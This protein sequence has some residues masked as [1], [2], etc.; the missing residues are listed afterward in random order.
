MFAAFRPIHPAFALARPNVIATWS[1]SHL[2]S[3]RARIVKHHPDALEAAE[4]VQCQPPEVRYLMNRTNGGTVFL[5]RLPSSARELRSAE[6]A[7]AKVLTLGIIGSK[8]Q[9]PDPGDVDTR[10]LSGP[11]SP[12]DDVHV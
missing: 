11:Y 6:T 10:P 1:S 7:L 8:Y 12:H 4:I 3:L 5:A 9:A 2:E